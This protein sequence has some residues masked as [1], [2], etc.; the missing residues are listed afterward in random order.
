[1]GRGG[2]M[3]P[4]SKSAIFAILGA[5]LIAARLSDILQQFWAGLSIHY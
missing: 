1:M 5:L 4:A 2:F 3:P